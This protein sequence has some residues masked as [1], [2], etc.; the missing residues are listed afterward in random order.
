MDRNPYAPPESVVTDA[1]VEA[2]RPREIVIAVGILWCAMTFGCILVLSSA[3]DATFAISDPRFALSLLP[4]ATY[5]GAF[6]LVNMS[7]SRGRN[8]ARIVFL[9]YVLYALCTKF[10]LGFGQLAW[11]DARSIIISVAELA[12][13]LIPL[14]LLFT[15]P[16]RKWFKR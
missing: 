2:P 5:F 7:L 1:P 8:W 12:V 16:A 15:G 10:I 11:P 13:V 9:L 4:A 14:Y 3:K 6:A